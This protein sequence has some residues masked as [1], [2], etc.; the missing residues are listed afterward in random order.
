MSD[1]EFCFSNPVNYSSEWNRLLPVPHSDPVFTQR[2]C[3]YSVPWSKVD[4]PPQLNNNSQMAGCT[5]VKKGLPFGLYFLG[6]Q[7]GT[8]YTVPA[9]KDIVLEFFRL[10]A[11][12]QR[13]QQTF[14]SQNRMKTSNCSFMVQHAT[15]CLER[16]ATTSTCVISSIACYATSFGSRSM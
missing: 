11:I 7:P 8:V 15:A 2:E 12:E 10:V 5:L 9:S 14:S 13:W 1:D 3:G 6:G 16:T 4:Y